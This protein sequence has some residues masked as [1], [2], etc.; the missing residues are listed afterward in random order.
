MLTDTETAIITATF[1][2][3]MNSSP[4]YALNGG[5]YTNLSP[6]GDPKIWTFLLDPTSLTPN[7]YTLTVTGT[8]VSGGYT[9]DPSSWN[10]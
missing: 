5:A 10:L 9:Y 7:Q 2:K 6:T 3:D 1:N 4:Q 8:C